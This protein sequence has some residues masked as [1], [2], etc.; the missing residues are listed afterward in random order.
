M[1][2]LICAGMSLL[3]WLGKSNSRI[4]T[5]TPSPIRKPVR[6]V[7]GVLGT[8]S[9][10]RDEDLDSHWMGPIVE[11]WGT[12]DLIMLPAESDSSQAIQEWASIKEIP[13]QLCSADWAKQG[14]RAGILRDA[15]IQRQA[16]HF[17]LL[18]GPRSNALTELAKKIHAK[19]RPVV[20]SERPGMAVVLPDDIVSSK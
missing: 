1:Y 18:Q 4:H 17:L 13:V 15:Q 11:A 10:I 19:G 12:P 20:I 3:A 9:I 5:R 8:R 14:R 16:N 2:P 6:M 7:L